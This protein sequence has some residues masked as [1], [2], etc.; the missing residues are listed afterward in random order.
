MELQRLQTALP[1]LNSNAAKSALLSLVEMSSTATGQSTFYNS[2]EEQDKAALA[3]HSAVFQLDRGVY[4]ALMTLPGVTDFSKQAAMFNLLSTAYPTEKRLSMSV[5]METKLIK[6]LLTTMPVHRVL[7]LFIK[8]AEQKQNSNRIRKISLKYIFGSDRLDFWA[9]KY[10]NK[11][12]QVIS[13]AIGKRRTGIIKKICAK[14]YEAWTIEEATIYTDNIG[15]HVKGDRNRAIQNVGFILRAEGMNINGEASKYLQAYNSAKVDINAGKDLPPEVLEGIRSQ[16]HP[17]VPKEKVL[18]LTAKTAT[19]TQ[20]MRSQKRAKKA[21]VEVKFDPF[22]MDAVKLYIYSFNEG[23]T[24]D[25]GKALTAKARNTAK[26]M[27]SSYGKVGILV[28]NSRSME[29]GKTQKY[30]PLS[31]GLALRDVIKEAS[32]NAV[33]RYSDGNG[34]RG[35]MAYPQNGTNLARGL[36][37]LYE[38]NPDV[39]YII[40]DGYENQ[41]AGR[42][43]E[44]ISLAKNKLGLDIPVIHLNPVAASEVVGV[45][46]LGSST[47]LS[48]SSPESFAQMSLR[49]GLLSALDRTL[50]AFFTKTITMLTA[51][52]TVG[53]GNDR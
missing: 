20:A 39:I 44:V 2:K 4:S 53:A 3:A 23:M 35:R 34:V 45:R 8:L 26:S 21:N 24:E 43:G 32:D 11:L 12:A 19:A 50:E 14:P 52:H 33:I 17:D 5:T 37:E 49:T 10:R 16:Y 9:V 30:R 13:H 28:D 6:Y 22:K 31:V 25:I 41:A 38:E 29:G 1:K 40:S 7:N 18:E 27:L 47:V 15:K 48:V 51:H 46:Q 42:V 36:I